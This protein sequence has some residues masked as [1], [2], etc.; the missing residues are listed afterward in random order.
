MEFT[1]YMVIALVGTGLFF[2][3]L[4]LFLYGAD[5]DIDINFGSVHAFEVLSLQSILATLMGVGWAGL[6][7]HYEFD[8]SIFTTLILSIFLA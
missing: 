3:K 1:I 4:V 7:L 2:I 5:A 6:A 8:T